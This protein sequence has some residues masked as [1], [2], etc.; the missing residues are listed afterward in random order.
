LNVSGMGENK[1]KKYG[2]R[3]IAYLNIL[4]EEVEKQGLLL[5]EVIKKEHFDIALKKVGIGNAIKSIHALQRMNF[6]EIF[7]SINGVEE[8][9]KE[10][11]SGVY[12]KMDYKTKEAYRNAIKEIADKTKISEIYIS[13]KAIELAKREDKGTKNNHVG[14]YL[15]DKRNTRSVSFNWYKKM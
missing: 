11:P 5:S 2:K 13:K 10:D 1:L 3:G 6:S 12:E 9:L 14:Y 15:L 7:E 4:E 8:I